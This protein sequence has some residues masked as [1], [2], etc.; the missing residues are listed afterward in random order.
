MTPLIKHNEAMR[1]F[2][3]SPNEKQLRQLVDLDNIDLVLRKLLT[4][5]EMREAGSFFTGQDLA[6]KTVSAFRTPITFSSVVLDPTCGAG[7]LLIEASRKL[8]LETTLS[9]TLR[10]W[11]DVLWGFDI[12]IHFIEATK[13]RLIIEALNRG[14]EQDCELEEAFVLLP[15][16]KVQDALVVEKEELETV[17]HVIMNPPFTIWISPKENYWKDGKVNAA[18]IIFDK[19]LRILQEGCNVS[20]VLPDVLRSGSRYQAFRG[21]VSSSMIATAEVWGRF[22]KKT[23][24]D[25]FILSGFLKSNAGKLQWYKPEITTSSISDFFEVRTGP[26]VAYRDPEEGVEYPYFYP[27]NCPQWEVILSATETR[28]FLGKALN[29]PLIVIKRTSSPSD[30]N[31]ASATLINLRE[32]VAIE[33]HMIVVKPKDGKLKTC[34]KLMQ[35]LQH[36][37]TNDFLNER[38]RLRHLTV[39]VVKDIPFKEDK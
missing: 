14:V 18:G 23:D 24:V 21:F 3:L 20:A 19:Y 17:T 35:A 16:I 2:L 38:I 11:G 13:L 9:A 36:Q 30:R 7:N 27:K 22:N 39:G 15:N 31:R 25:V 37:Q 26:L 32:P 12:H 4:I 10:A 1:D 5:E 29:P 28:K 6:S 34:K 8:G 33:N